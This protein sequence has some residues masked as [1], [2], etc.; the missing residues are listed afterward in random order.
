M[1]CSCCSCAGVLYR[2][3]KKRAEAE[4]LDAIKVSEARF[5]TLI[6]DAPIAIAIL[7]NAHI[8]YANPRYRMLHGYTAGRRSAGRSLERHDRAGIA[9]ASAARRKS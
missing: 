5:R 3:Q 6:E 9:L 1:G 7:R 2:T 4:S 8:I